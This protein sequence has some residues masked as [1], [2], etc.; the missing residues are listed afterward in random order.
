M[1]MENAL[2][3]PFVNRQFTDFFTP[4][5]DLENCYVSHVLYQFDYISSCKKG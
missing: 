1:V 3:A 2:W 4:D 5:M